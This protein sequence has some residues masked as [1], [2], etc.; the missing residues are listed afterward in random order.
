MTVFTSYYCAYMT[1]KN[2]IWPL[3]KAVNN[4]RKLSVIYDCHPTD[5]DKWSLYINKYGGQEDASQRLMTKI[6]TRV[7]V[8][9]KRKRPCMQGKV[10]RQCKRHK[11][12]LLTDELSLTLS[13]S[14]TKG[15]QVKH[16]FHWLFLISNHDIWEWYTKKF[17][18][19]S[20]KNAILIA[21]APT[22]SAN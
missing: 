19:F 14:L 2:Y 3:L 9:V 21:D 11:Y 7:N 20:T 5:T 17:V 1:T 22:P 13:F 4:H 8:K 6:W 16:T 15:L 18:S 10:H 12:A